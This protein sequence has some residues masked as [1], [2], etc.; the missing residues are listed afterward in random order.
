MA[1]R[2]AKRM[3]RNSTRSYFGTTSLS[4][5]RE[6]SYV[7]HTPHEVQRQHAH[8]HAHAHTY[9]D[10]R[11]PPPH[12][13]FLSQIHTVTLRSACV[14]DRPPHRHLTVGTW[15]GWWAVPSILFNCAPHHHVTTSQVTRLRAL[16][17]S[18]N[19][20]SSTTAKVS[21]TYLAPS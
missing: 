5:G 21:S 8:A 6:V 2:M 9:A 17:F 13:L 12:T 11:S 16:I 10:P 18:L 1:K 20:S 3:S 19:T 4:V 7:T 14:K 15:L